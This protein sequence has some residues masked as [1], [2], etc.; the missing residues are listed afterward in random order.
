MVHGAPSGGPS[1]ALGPVRRTL[2]VHPWPPR[3][4]PSPLDIYAASGCSNVQKSRARSPG[5][6]AVPSRRAPGRPSQQPH[7]AEP[8][9]DVNRRSPG[10]VNRQLPAG[11]TSPGR[12]PILEGLVS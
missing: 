2:P 12:G 4:H 7:A 9:G 3:A 10:R 1:P 8:P 6:L 5:G 11:R